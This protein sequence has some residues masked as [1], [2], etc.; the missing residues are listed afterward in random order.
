MAGN[1]MKERYGGL[2]GSFSLQL[3][4]FKQ[5]AMASIEQ[6]IKDVVIQI[7]ETIINLAPV[8]TG[9]FK[10]SFQFTVGAPANFSPIRYDKEGTIALA[11]LNARVAQ[12]DTSQVAY[13]VS[14]LVYAISLEYGHSS[15]APSGVIR[16]T[17]AQFEKIVA[18]AAALNEAK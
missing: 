16:I 14:N 4:Q 10:G 9:R 1:H 12:W 6:T 17:I 8:D 11:E 2:T 18:A 5:K 15:Q 7:G 13:F 3:D